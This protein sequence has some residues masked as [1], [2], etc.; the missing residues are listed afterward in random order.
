MP[1]IPDRYLI[2]KQ[3]K[4]NTKYTDNNR[5]QV[6]ALHEAGYAQRAIAR[7]IPMSRRMVSFIL[8]PE[9]MAKCKEQYAQRQKDG[10]YRYPTAVQ[11]AM[12]AKVRNRKKKSLM[13]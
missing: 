13:N 8:F 12:V 5:F 2:P 6:L 7:M 9:R 4:L 1:T 10:R 3:L 11:S